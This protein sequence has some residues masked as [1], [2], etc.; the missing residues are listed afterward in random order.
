MANWAL[1]FQTAVFRPCMPAGERAEHGSLKVQG[2]I[3]HLLPVCLVRQIGSPHLAGTA[4]V[5]QLKSVSRNGLSLAY[6]DYLFPNHR[7]R[8]VAPDLFLRN[9]A[10]SSLRS[11]GYKLP[12]SHV[13]GK[14]NICNPLRN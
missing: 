7:G 10:K 2:P 5:F 4:R 3:R 1:N 14:I 12:S 6:T 9:S 8:V 11:F 13:A